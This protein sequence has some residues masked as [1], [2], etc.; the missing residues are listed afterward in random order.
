MAEVFVRAAAVV[1]TLGL[2]IM[3]IC[4]VLHTLGLRRSERLQGFNGRHPWIGMATGLSAGTAEE[5]VGPTTAR[6][7]RV[8]SLVGAAIIIP[9]SMA[10]MLIFV[11]AALFAE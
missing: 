7:L 6:F 1:L 9:T 2:G 11:A 3:W 5:K 8:V 4:F 10:V